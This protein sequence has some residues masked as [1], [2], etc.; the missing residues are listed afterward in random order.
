MLVCLTF[1]FRSRATIITLALYYIDVLLLLSLDGM[2]TF[3]VTRFYVIV[4]SKLTLEV[5]KRSAQQKESYI[6]VDL[7]IYSKYWHVLH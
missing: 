1:I 7:D 5:L 3:A 6:E 4:T 2:S